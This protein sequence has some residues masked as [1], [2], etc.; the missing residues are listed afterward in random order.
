MSI[1]SNS[2]SRNQFTLIGTCDLDLSP[3]GQNISRFAIKNKSLCD[4][5]CWSEKN[6]SR[7]FCKILKFKIYFFTTNQSNLYMRKKF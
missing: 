3:F 6:R 4:I 1:V 5:F 2:I 7:Y